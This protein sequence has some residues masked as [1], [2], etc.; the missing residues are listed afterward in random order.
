VTFDPYSDRRK[1]ERSDLF[2][3]DAKI[4]F[5]RVFLARVRASAAEYRR[6][7]AGRPCHATP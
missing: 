1:P 6:T 7:R 2:I 5:A 4:R 3:V